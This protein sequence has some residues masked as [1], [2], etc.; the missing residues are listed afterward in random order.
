MARAR[1]YEEARA[2]LSGLQLYETERVRSYLYTGGLV[3]VHAE[4]R[5]REAIWEAMER[6]EVYSTSG[7][8]LLLWFDLIEEDGTRPMGSELTL[9]D[10]PVFRVRAVGSRV[11]APGCP[12]RLP[13]TVHAHLP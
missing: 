3:A 4:G 9:R 5:S 6:K 11:Q 1:S 8:R 13:R 2:S 12:Q 10:A 7:P